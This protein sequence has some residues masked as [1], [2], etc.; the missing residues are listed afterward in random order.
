MNEQSDFLVIGS[1]IAGLSFALKAAELGTVTILTKSHIMETNT[2]YAQ[3]GIASVMSTADNFEKHIQDTLDAGDGICDQQIVEMVVKEAP[4]RIQDLID[5]GVAFDRKDDGYYDLGR[6]GGHSEKRILHSKDSTGMAIIN[7]LIEQVLTHP[8]ILVKEFHFAIDLI[9]QHHMGKLV[10]KGQKDTECF[11]A[12]ILNIKTGEIITF[13]SKATVL[14]TG[15]SGNVYAT[16]TNPL[17]ATGDGIAMV[18]RA[19]GDVK[20]MEF[21]QFHPT[22][23]YNTSERPSFLITEAMR[24]AGAILKTLD[25]KEFMHN[26]DER[27]S[28][29]SRD[30][31][32]RAMDNEMKKRG[33]DYVYLDC[34]AIGEDAL[35]S[36]FPNIYE[37]CK[38]LSIDIST[39][40][41][42]VVPAAHYQCGG[43]TVDIN[44]CSS[45]NRLFALGE[46]SCTGL[47][48]AN[49]L[50]SNSLLEAVVYADRAFHYA[51]NNII[52]WHIQPDI[53]NWNSEGTTEPKE[54]V[55]ITQNY[56]EVQQLMSNY[57]G[58]VRSNDR[59]SRAMD[60]LEIIHSETETLYEKTLISRQLCELRNLINV[61]YLII[62]HAQGRRE[63]RG[64][65]YTMDY[66][67]KIHNL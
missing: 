1:G 11:G 44:G 4:D 26:Y 55:M 66:P 6:E 36:H 39:D 19:K 16:T 12:Y 2:W 37:K 15:G 54:M 62:K 59:L 25:G 9:T 35:K 8:N 50:A 28:L 51:K 14:C 61:A 58:I 33:E 65:H 47:H 18:H 5:W 67:Y 17:I 57:V 20:N 45:I 7:A 46:V 52:N 60:R 31:V 21:I 56:R 23:L 53:P 43:V 34:T 24:G 38:S 3:G 29:A 32:A 27:R 64:L 63:S 48:G 13:L 10:K 41:I 49:R 42:P 30:I 22:S 40:F